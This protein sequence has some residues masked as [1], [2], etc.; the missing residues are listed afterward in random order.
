MRILKAGSIYFLIVFG[1]GLALAFVRVPFLV[2]HF[3]VRVAE[4]LDLPVMLA[5]IVWASRR[6][7]SRNPGLGHRARVLS[8][9]LALVLLVGGE[10]V[11]ACLPGTR[12]P[13]EYIAS[14][15]PVSGGVYLVSLVFFA[16]APGLWKRPAG[17]A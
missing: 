10:L 17:G 14:R 9:L 13:G 1:A 16:L 2:P 4:L 3:G 5:V 7:V 12:S 8:G 15:D 11:V 6:L